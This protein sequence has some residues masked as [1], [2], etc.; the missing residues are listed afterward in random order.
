[1]ML[2]FLGP[3]KHPCFKKYVS[4]RTNAWERSFHIVFYEN[5]VQ[6]KRNQDPTAVIHACPP[7]L[8]RSTQTVS[9]SVACASTQ[10]SVDIALEAEDV[11]R[12]SLSWKHTSKCEHPLG[13]L[14][15]RYQDSRP[16]GWFL[17]IALWGRQ[18]FSRLLSDQ[19][20]Y[21]YLQKRDGWYNN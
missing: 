4:C 11:L 9:P 19:K 1:M 6:T 16:R 2:C 7:S 3:W 10:L 8:L 21:H 12:E 18:T 15:T 17:R 20:C 13:A 5:M 14:L